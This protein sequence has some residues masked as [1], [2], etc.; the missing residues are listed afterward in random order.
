M[1]FDCSF[2]LF[3][4]KCTEIL[5]VH[6]PHL[7][8]SGNWNLNGCPS[9]V[10]ILIPLAF[11]FHFRA[12]LP[13][14]ILLTS[15]NMNQI[16]ASCHRAAW[17]RSLRSSF[18]FSFFW[19]SCSSWNFPESQECSLTSSPC[20]ACF[21]EMQVEGKVERKVLI[22]GVQ[23]QFSKCRQ[24]RRVMLAGACLPSTA[25]CPAEHSPEL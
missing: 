9:L 16:I 4:R 17:G 11:Y 2:N 6:W 15:Q 8:I 23:T 13:G 24:L 5:H 1:A 14:D 22:F 19:A 3:W 21:S 18:N 20:D 10:L 12:F 7:E 25:V